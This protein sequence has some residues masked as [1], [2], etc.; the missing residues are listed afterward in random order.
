MLGFIRN[1]KKLTALLIPVLA[2][3]GFVGILGFVGFVGWDL[4]AVIGLL[5]AEFDL[6]RGHYEVLAFGLLAS[7]EA[8]YAR[9]L[10]E[11][12]GIEER[13][14]AGCVVS[15]WLP[16]YVEGYNRTAM[17]AAN[18]RFGRDVF[19]ESAADAFRNWQLQHPR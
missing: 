5:S 10:R 8:E 9:L 13:V 14:V 19:Q 2:L 12:Y 15:P 18:R 7:W 4:P 1:H 11:R 6:M 16:P 17:G 3:W